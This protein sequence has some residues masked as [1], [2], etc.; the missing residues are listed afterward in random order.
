[1]ERVVK[2]DLTNILNYNILKY[3]IWESSSGGERIQSIGA[4][5]RD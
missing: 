5:G 4:T 3:M 1:M 2:K